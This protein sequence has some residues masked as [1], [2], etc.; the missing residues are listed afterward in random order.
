MKIQLKYPVSDAD[1]T[2]FRELTLRRPTVKDLK[3]ID[4]AK[5]EIEKAAIL[6][7]Q[8]AR[9]ENGSALTPIAVE[10]ID[11]EDFAEISEALSSFFET[12]PQIGD[13]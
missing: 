7:G 3:A 13:K 5:G 12:S 10:R 8:L 1:G 11:A 4:E 6:I 2:E 9:G